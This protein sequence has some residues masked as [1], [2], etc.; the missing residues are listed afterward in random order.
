MPWKLPGPKSPEDLTD[1]RKELLF[2]DGYDATPGVIALTSTPNNTDFDQPVFGSD[3]NL[4]GTNSTSS[5]L[6]LT[7]LE[8]N[9]KSNGL[10]HLL[11]GKRPDTNPLNAPKQYRPRD[12]ESVNVLILRKKNDDS[13]II[14]SRLFPKVQFAA[15]YPEGGPDDK[16]QRVFNGKGAPAREF[17]GLMTCD[18]VQSGENLRSSPYAVDGESASTFAVYI[19]ALSFP[20]GD[21]S[22]EAD[23]DPIKTVTPAMVSSAGVVDWAS[24]TAAVQIQ[25]VNYAHIYYLVSGVTGIP[26]TNTTIEPEGMRGAPL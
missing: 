12:L 3:E 16:S 24:I 25:S 4:A 9:E 26:E 5:N 20:G 22:A 7:L 2:C 6:S 15:A 18:L 10:L 17:D 13:K 11:H 1:R 14:Q 19:E 23:R 21:L 8:Q